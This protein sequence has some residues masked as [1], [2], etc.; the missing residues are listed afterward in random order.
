M[1]AL[2]TARAYVASYASVVTTTERKMMKR[3]RRRSCMRDGVNPVATTDSGE[4]GVDEGSLCETEK[5]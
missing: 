1:A 5:G 3:S 4:I 2:V